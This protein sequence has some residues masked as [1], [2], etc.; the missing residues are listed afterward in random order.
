M[1]VGPGPD[2]VLP[3][4]SSCGIPEGGKYAQCPGDGPAPNRPYPQE[5]ASDDWNA[6]GSVRREEGDGGVLV[7][8]TA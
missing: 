8:S 2:P 7:R 4:K 3:I 1:R 6:P 5:R